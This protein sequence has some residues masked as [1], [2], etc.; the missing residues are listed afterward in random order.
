MNP[1]VLSVFG[2]SAPVASS[3]WSRRGQPSALPSALLALVKRRF[4][5][6]SL[7]RENEHFGKEVLLFRQVRILSSTAKLPLR[8][9]KSSLPKAPLL[10][11]GIKKPRLRRTERVFFFGTRSGFSLRVGSTCHTPRERTSCGR[12]AVFKRREDG[13]RK[14][15]E[16]ER[17]EQNGALFW[18]KSQIQKRLLAAQFAS[19]TNQISSRG[20]EETDVKGREATLCSQISNFPQG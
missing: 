17:A 2:L 19:E 18:L 20:E 15:I 16:N 1:S 9:G 8:S 11:S 5:T 7:E 6:N 4:L 13:Y 14:S 3:L 10:Q 12:T